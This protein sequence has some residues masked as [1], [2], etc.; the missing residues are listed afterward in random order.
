MTDIKYTIRHSYSV[1]HNT[2]YRGGLQT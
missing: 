1:S 2:S